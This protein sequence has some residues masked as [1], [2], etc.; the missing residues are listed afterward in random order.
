M[1]SVSNAVRHEKNLLPTK[2]ETN[3]QIQQ[4]VRA[5]EIEL[6]LTSFYL[7][8]LLRN[9]S[10]TTTEERI[11]TVLGSITTLP[12][13][14]IRIPKDPLYG[15]PRGVCFVELHTTLEAS[16]LFTLLSSLSSGFVIDDYPLSVGYAKRNVPLSISAGG[17]STA[18]VR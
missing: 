5:N 3:L 11:L 8:L 13:K 7:G 6:Y 18:S 15:V 1:S 2:L 9:I 17:V 4:T 10:Q 16:Q 14:S 12:I